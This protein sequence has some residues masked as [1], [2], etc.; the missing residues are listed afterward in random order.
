MKTK[1]PVIW[2]AGATGVVGAALAPLL[3]SQ[4]AVVA[5]SGRD[6]S[7]LQAVASAVAQAG[8]A[9]RVY[10]L[11]VRDGPA[12]SAVAERIVAD[13]GGI[14]GLV[15]SMAARAFGDFLTLPDD[16]WHDVLETKFMG[17]LRTMRAVIPHMRERGGGSIVNISGRG[18]RQPTPAHL[19]GGSANAGINLLSKGLA[20]IFQPDGIR[21]NVV[22]PGP[23]ESERFD[24]IEKSNVRAWGGENRRAALDRRA[25]PIDIA[26]AVAFLL[27]PQSSHITGVVLAV[28]GGGTATV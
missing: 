1:G 18:G 13:C 2:V 10:E 14:D 28:D 7:K 27:A 19:P 6:E 5:I 24:I 3:A 11:D 23:V 16:A 17:Y 20:D 15:N 26:N 9:P 22:A 25:Q 12:V 21:V 4:G 8:A